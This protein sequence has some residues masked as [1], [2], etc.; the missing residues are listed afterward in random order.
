MRV[1]P[2]IVI[3][4]DASMIKNQRHPPGGLDINATGIRNANQLAHSK[5]LDERAR[6]E[7]CDVAKKL[8]FDDGTLDRCFRMMSL[9]P[10]SGPDGGD[11]RVERS[12]T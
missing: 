6:F 4:Y 3:Y 11:G 2:P 8:P 5:G 7:K 12:Y 1:V 10:R 9:C